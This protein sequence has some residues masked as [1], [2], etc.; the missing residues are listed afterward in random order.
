LNPSFES[1]AIGPASEQPGAPADWVSSGGIDYLISNGY[2]DNWLP[3]TDGTQLA[4][5]LS[6]SV[7]ETLSQSGIELTAGLSYRLNLDLSKYV[8]QPSGA[9]TVTLSDGVSTLAQS[10]TTVANDW[11]SEGW[12]LVAPE[13]GDYTLA[14]SAGVGTYPAIDNL[15]LSEYS[16][17]PEPG[18]AGLFMGSVALAAAAK[19]AR[20]S[21]STSAALQAARGR[22]S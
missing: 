12:Q 3:A 5:L 10:F 8:P 17:V 18:W 4:Y 16:A 9:I 11:T 2:S 22:S 6:S 14:I 15:S 19:R 13:S 7:P 1:P 20:R 21:R